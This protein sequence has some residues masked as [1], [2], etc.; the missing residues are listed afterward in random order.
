MLTTHL[1][2]KKSHHPHQMSSMICVGLIGAQRPKARAEGTAIWFYQWEL[3]QAV[4]K[5]IRT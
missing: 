1:G 5:T 3:E 4:G 2:E